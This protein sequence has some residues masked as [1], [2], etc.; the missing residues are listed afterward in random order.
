MI[1]KSRIPQ[2]RSILCTGTKETAPSLLDECNVDFYEGSEGS[3][4]EEG[5]EGRSKEKKRVKKEGKLAS[6]TLVPLPPPK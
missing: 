2:S 6:P 3:G 1:G 4:I 5:E